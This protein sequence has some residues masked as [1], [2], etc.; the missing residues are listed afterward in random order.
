MDTQETLSSAEVERLGQVEDLIRR[1]FGEEMD[2]DEPILGMA[3]TDIIA[4]NIHELIHDSS[5]T[6][7]TL[8]VDGKVVGASLAVPFEKMKIVSDEEAKDTAYIYFTG[9][10][11]DRQ[12]E[13][14][15]E[16]VNDSMIEELKARD[17][18]FVARDS[19]LTQN[20]ADKVEK[21]YDDAIVER[22]YHERWPEIGKQ[23]F[24]KIELAKVASK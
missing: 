5:T 10:E 24:L 18:K 14:L 13:G 3:E 19:V 21:A 20:Y 11:P 1:V 9:V 2:L 7:A 6:I 12:G 17:Y 16:A 15:V 8:E 4:A 23:R 22:Y